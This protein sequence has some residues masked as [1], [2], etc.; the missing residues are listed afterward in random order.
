MIHQLK[1]L[2]TITHKLILKGKKF[3]FF[4]AKHFGTVKE[5]PPGGPPRSTGIWQQDPYL[6]FFISDTYI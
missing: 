6:R 1:L 4:T 5:K 3:Q 2:Q